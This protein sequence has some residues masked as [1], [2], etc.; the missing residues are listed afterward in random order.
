[1]RSVYCHEPRAGRGYSSGALATFVLA[2]C[3]A[4]PVSA[5]A[6]TV[7]FRAD[8][9]G[10]N[11]VP[12]TASSASGYVRAT[13]DTAT[14]RLSWTGSQSG[15]SSKITHIDFHGPAGPAE[16]AGVV[17]PINSLSEGST[18]LSDAEAAGLIGGYWSLIIHTRSHPEGEIRGQVYRGE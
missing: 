1:M 12:P 13:Y 18:T 3:L 7:A 10:A 4:V 11:M 8:L 15:L 6:S 17:Q 9:K 14:R 16:A 5:S 2:V